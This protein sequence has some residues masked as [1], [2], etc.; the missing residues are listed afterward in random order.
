VRE[1]RLKDKVRL[2][3]ARAVRKAAVRGV[4]LLVAA[5]AGFTLRGCPSFHRPVTVTSFSPDDALRV[6]VVERPGYIDRNFEVRLEDTAT[7]QTR[8]VFQ[9]PDEGRPIGSE[10]VVW[11]A[12]GSRFLLL[13]RHFFV[14]ER[15]KLST[16]EQAYLMMD[17]RT[18]QVWCNASQQSQHVGFGVEALRTVRWVG[19]PPSDSTQET[20]PAQGL[21]PPGSNRL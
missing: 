18:G 5:A 14:T 16:G 19:W 9:S 6:V 1:Y 15:G 11:S 21:S 8:T 4:A 3:E 13:G 10:R 2:P 12:D 17:V 7:G 20:G